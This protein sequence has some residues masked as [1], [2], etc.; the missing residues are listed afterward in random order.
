MTKNWVINAQKEKLQNIII[1]DLEDF[2]AKHQIKPLKIIPHGKTEVRFFEVHFD[3]S[4]NFLMMETLKDEL[5]K[6]GY[7][8]KQFHSNL[9]ESFYLIVMRVLPI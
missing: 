4:S 5:E 8:P 6:A 9:P 1:K 3:N 2:M 7:S